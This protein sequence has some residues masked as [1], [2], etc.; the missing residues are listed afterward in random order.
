MI[1]EINAKQFMHLPFNPVRSI[2][3][4]RKGFNL[5]IFLVKNYMNIKYQSY[6]IFAEMIMNLKSSF[7]M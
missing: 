2:E 4:I 6:S 7:C 5:R 1:Q 3:H